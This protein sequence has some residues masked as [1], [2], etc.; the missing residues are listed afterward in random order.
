MWLAAHHARWRSPSRLS[1]RTPLLLDLGDQGIVRRDKQC[2]AFLFQLVGDRVIV[3]T[4]LL[5]R[6]DHPAG[7]IQLRVDGSADV[8]MI[9]EGL[10]R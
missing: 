7:V 9:L 10:Q 2:G 6:R 8:A 4:E 5:E 3:D 1:Y